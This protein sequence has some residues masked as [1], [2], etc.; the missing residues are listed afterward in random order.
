MEQGDMMIFK[1]STASDILAPNEGRLHKG[2]P[3]K[4]VRK[5]LDRAGRSTESQL[6]RAG[7]Q[8]E[9]EVSRGSEN[10]QSSD[11]WEKT[12]SAALAGLGDPRTWATYGISAGTGLDA[13]STAESAEAAYAEMSEAEQAE[14]RAEIEAAQAAQEEARLQQEAEDAQREQER[15]TSERAKAAEDAARERATRLGKGR[16]GLLYEGATGVKSKDVLGG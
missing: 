5:E 6:S 10:V 16:R 2:N 1:Y 3:L 4:K 14:A 15:M 8:I 13:L 9:S 11:W 7:K 12:G